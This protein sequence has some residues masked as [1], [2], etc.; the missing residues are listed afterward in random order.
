MVVRALLVP[1]GVD[2][3][4]VWLLPEE[5]P[6]GGRFLCPECRSRLIVR[7]GEGI[8]RH[9]AHFV[10]SAGCAF[11]GE[12]AE[13]LAAKYLV[14]ATVKRWRAGRAL[15]PQVRTRCRGCH[16]TAMLRPL[17]RGIADAAVEAEVAIPGSD[18][19]LRL[20]VALLDA[21]GRVRLAVEIR[22]SH[23]VPQE[24]GAQL[25]RARIPW[26]EVEASA[27]T[28]RPSSDLLAVSG[29]GVDLVQECDRCRAAR[30]AEAMKMGARGKARSLAAPRS[31]FEHSL[32]SQPSWTERQREVLGRHFPQQRAA[33]ILA[34]LRRAYPA[35]RLLEGYEGRLRMTG[36]LAPKQVAR[37]VMIAQRGVAGLDAAGVVHAVEGRR[38]P[39][40]PPEGTKE[41]TLF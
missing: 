34:E 36:R 12:S 19:R 2:A 27:L 28:G 8:V 21:R 17:R 32:S 20:D 10:H 15:S 9:F 40:P 33:R 3:A 13:H 6:D 14:A 29:G 22:R 23:A 35:L 16:A 37:I 7:E 18:A 31:K 4:G 41:P 1:V 26:I 11:A 24:K 30:L 25:Q 5:A 38:E 39:S